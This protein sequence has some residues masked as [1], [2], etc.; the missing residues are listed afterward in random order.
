MIRKRQRWLLDVLAACIVMLALVPRAAS[1]AATQPQACAAETGRVV[2][3]VKPSATDPAISRFDTA[4]YILF[5]ANTGPDASL[6]VFLPG[7]GGE[8]SG[9]VPLLAAA[10]DAGY[11]VISLSGRI[12]PS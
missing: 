3:C 10:A 6:L 7:T 2:E 12:P 8:P 4:H 11:R 9:P 1:R 5:N